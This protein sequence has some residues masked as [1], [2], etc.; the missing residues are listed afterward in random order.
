MSPD[1]PE[2]REAEAEEQSADAQEELDAAT[3]LADFYDDA[4]YL[5]HWLDRV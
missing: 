1:G 3:E 5:S 2:Q 4:E